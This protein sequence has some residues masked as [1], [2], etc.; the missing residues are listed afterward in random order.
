MCRLAT[1]DVATN[2]QK[3][4]VKRNGNWTFNPS[5]KLWAFNPFLLG[6][7][8]EVAGVVFKVDNVVGCSFTLDTK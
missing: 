7:R 2:A 5:W 6:Q 1:V 8:I 4:V 3:R